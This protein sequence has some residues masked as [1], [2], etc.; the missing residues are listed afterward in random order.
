MAPRGARAGAAASTRP[1][2]GPAQPHGRGR[3]LRAGARLGGA[4][5]RPGPGP[6]PPLAAAGAGARRRRRR[7]RRG[8]RPPAGSG[9]AA[10]R[11]SGGRPL[12]V[13]LA[14]A[15]ARL[16]GGDVK[17]GE[18]PPPLPW[19]YGARGAPSG[20]GEQCT[21]GRKRE[22]GRGNSRRA[23]ASP[24]NGPATA[25]GASRLAGVK[26][27]QIRPKRNFLLQ[28]PLGLSFSFCPASFLSL[29]PSPPP[30]PEIYFFSLLGLRVTG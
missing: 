13:Q 19:R 30:P 26:K 5:G 14:A 7:P 27:R 1:S 4:A 12:G 20:G 6:P 9:R 17:L 18:P 25:V 10:A 22:G 28:L 2:P 24:G 11:L 16:G 29:P 3:E 8:P 23:G 15:A 21:A